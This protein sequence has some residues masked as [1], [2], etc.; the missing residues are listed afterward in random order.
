[1]E[2]IAVKMRR[3]DFLTS[4]GGFLRQVLG[5][6]P[7]PPPAAGTEAPAATRPGTHP[8][9]PPSFPGKATLAQPKL[10]ELKD[11]AAGQPRHTLTES[12]SGQHTHP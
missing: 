3:W 9:E 7:A 12:V 8:A 10:A 2:L 1:M 5:D 6:M 4:E 11:P